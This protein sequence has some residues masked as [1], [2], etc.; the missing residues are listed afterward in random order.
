MPRPEQRDDHLH[1]RRPRGQAPENVDARRRRQVRRRRDPGLLLRA[2]ARPAGR[3]LPHVPR[4][5]RGHPE[6][7]DRRARR[8][9]RTAWSSTPRPT[10]VHEAQEAVVEFLLINHPLDCPVCDKGGECPLQD[11]TFGWGGGTLALHRAQAPLRASRSSC[12]PLIAIDRERCILCYR[13][14]RFSQ[15]ISED[16]QLV[17]ARA[18]RAHVRRHVR[19]PPLRRAVQRQHH[20]A[21]PGRRADLAALPLPRAPVGHRGRGLGLHAVPGAVQRRASPS[22]TSASCACSRATTPRSTTAGCATRAASPTRPIHVDERI[23]AAAACAT[24]A[25]CARSRGSARS[26]TAARRARRAR[27]AASARSP[28]A[29]RPTRRASCSQRLLREGLGSRDLD[30]RAGGALPRRACTRALRAP[31][32]AG[33]GR[34]TSSSPTPCSCS[35]ASRSTTR[36]SSTCA[37]ARACAATACKLAVATSRPSSLDPNAERRRCASRP[38]PAR[39]CSCALDAALAG[40]A[41]TLGGAGRRGRRRRRRR[42]ARSPTL[43]RERRRGRRDRLRRAAARRPAR[44][45]TPPRALL[46]VAGAPRARAAATAPACSRSRPAPTAAACARPAC[47]P[48]PGPGYADA[49]ADGPRRRA[50]SPPALADGELTALY[51]LHADPLRDLPGPRRCGSAR[52][53]RATTVDRARALPHRGL[54]EH[55]DRRLP[56]R[57][58]RREGGHGHAPR[59]ARAAPAPGD[60]PPGRGARRV[61]GAR[62]ARRARVGLD[63]GV[64][65]RRRWP[66]RSSPRPCRSTPA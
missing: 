19:R 65:D 42:S 6:A 28:A 11:I 48:T 36:R 55:A 21:V 64:L 59:R 17:L 22:A 66:P 53:T 39:R 20:R 38:A 2:Q 25:S 45:R 30:S 12:S 8:R 26:T 63:L 60:R 3:R 57:G 13:C 35:T 24:A 29:R 23:T 18:R 5:D 50:R 41:A 9:S 10:R 7:A 62:R 47:C 33:D 34:R 52:W 14:V 37:S 40:D 15:E 31:G 16:Y 61:A 4:R 56:G 51:L 44:R 32:A 27:A 49:P 54:R 58:L 46:N 43:L 1:D